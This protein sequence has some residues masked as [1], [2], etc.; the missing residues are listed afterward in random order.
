MRAEW[1]N[2]AHVIIAAA[3]FNSA[4]LGVSLVHYV[5]NTPSI[6]YLDVS[7]EY[8]NR[9]VENR[10][11]LLSLLP[12]EN[13]FR[14]FD[15]LGLTARGYYPWYVQVSAARMTLVS[16]ST[17]IPYLLCLLWLA[18][19]CPRNIVPVAVLSL[20]LAFLTVAIVILM[21]GLPRGMY[22]HFLLTFLLTHTARSLLV[23]SLIY[24]FGCLRPGR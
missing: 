12:V 24:P 13:P 6:R 2:A 3:I 19:V 20:C 21:Q 11:P 5:F 23:L 22:A 17:A 14:F 10:F 15:C 1:K 7:T 8:H 16:L 18:M 9:L 4:F